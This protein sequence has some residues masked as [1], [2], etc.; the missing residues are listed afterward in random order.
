MNKY[1]SIKTCIIDSWKEFAT[2][3]KAYVK[4]LW[5]HLLIAGLGF[6]IFTAECSYIYSNNI[7]PTRLLK[8]SGLTEEVAKAIHGPSLQ[9]V[10][11]GILALL[12]FLLANYLM[13]GAIFSQIRFYKATGN[14]PDMGAFG[15][16]SEIKKDGLHTFVIDLI[17]AL[18][19]SVCVGIITL[20]AWL[21]SWWV[22]LLAIPILLYWTIIGTSGRLLY[23][24]E[25]CSL[26]QAIKGAFQTGHHK[27][28]GYLILLLLTS[29]PLLLI[30]AIAIQPVV[31]YLFA[32][33]A[34]AINQL[35]SEPSGMPSYTLILYFITATLSMCIM[36]FAYALQQMPL[37]LYTAA[38]HKK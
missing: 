24:V 29:I 31:V 9:I 16:W 35:I 5:L 4:Y 32:N 13:Q 23:I 2:N 36:G 18:S 19:I 11:I 33:N 7:I 17:I 10:G 21:T 6:S 25:K 12:A 8:E 28:G 26:K 14:L 30:I 3:T 20:I 37:A 27:F 22:L 15:F 38:V 1:T 34:N